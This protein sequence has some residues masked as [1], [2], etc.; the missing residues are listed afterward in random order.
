MK[1]QRSNSLQDIENRYVSTIKHE[2]LSK[3]F[4]PTRSLRYKNKKH[5]LA[6]TMMS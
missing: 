2:Y 4:Y 1:I 6:A 5:N 3:Q